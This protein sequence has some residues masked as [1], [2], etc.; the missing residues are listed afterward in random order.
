MA[1]PKINDSPKYEVTVPSTQK[2]IKYR[3]FLVKEQKILMMAMESQDQKQI[4]NAITDTIKSCVQEPLEVNKLTT[5]D[6]EY[7]FT[8]LR[9]KS[10]GEKATIGVDCSE[11]EHSNEVDV[12]V[13][14]IK[15]DIPKVNK[16]VKLTD[17]FLLTLRYP[18]YEFMMQDDIISGSSVEQLYAAIR[19]CLH[20]LETNEERIEFDE[21]P[22]EEV[23]KFLDQLDTSQFNAIM[24]FVNKIPKLTHK[25]NFE[26]ESC[27]HNNEI[28]LEGIKDFF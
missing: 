17:Q 12:R 26:C 16:K 25:I 19:M 3:P 20:T 15:I 6:V 8:Q 14:E 4:L 11:C 28:T 27:G 24:D 9:S 13:D 1:L 10:V 18:S 7:L 22:K 23:E 5:F 2:A 21:E